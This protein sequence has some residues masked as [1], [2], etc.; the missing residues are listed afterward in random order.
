M[1]LVQT[2][3]LNQISL[4]RK[5]KQ[6]N[7]KNTSKIQFTDNMETINIRTIQY[8]KK[9]GYLKFNWQIEQVK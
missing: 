2:Y 7:Y 3:T 6:F 4:G 5:F 1:N 9:Q 8:L